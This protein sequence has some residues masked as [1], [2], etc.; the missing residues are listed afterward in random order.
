MYQ[1][2]TSKLVLATA[3][4]LAGCTSY[5]AD[6]LRP[7]VELRTLQARTPERALPPSVQEDLG[8]RYRHEDGLDEAE[9]VIAA[10]NFNPELR[11]KRY[12]MSRL[13]GFDLLGM[14]KFKPELQVNLDRATVGVATD[15][16]TLYTLLIPS[17]RQAWRDD[18]SARREQS[19]AE[20]LAAEV[21]VVV[22]VRRAH[23]GVLAGAERLAW[24]QRRVV[25][26]RK[27]LDQVES[28][29][30][31]TPL[32]R[33]MASLAWERA[34]GDVRHES[35]GLDGARR[36]LNQTIGFDPRQELRLTAI[37]Q[38]LA[39]Q[40]SG[41]VS[42]DE[43]DQH[44]IAGRWELRAL[45][46]SYRRAEYTYSQ[47]VVGQYPKLRLAPAVSYDREEG[48]SFKLGASVKVPWPE[49]AERK[50]EDAHQERERARA[51]Y[52]ARLHQ[53]RAEAHAANARLAAAIADLTALERSRSVADAAL[54]AGT[55]RHEQGEL[56]L[57]DYLPLVERCEDI[58][59][60]WIEAA[61]DY[62]LSRI[63]VD[64]ATGRINQA[65]PEKSSP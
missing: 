38:P 34:L 2:M 64:H 50:M 51:V 19:R 5:R 37:G 41:V 63:D 16:D 44:L 6:P 36:I 60:A 12:G 59:R 58:A 29:P 53:L 55:S 62:R 18:E 14:V 24:A 33:A 13:G 56:S 43:L 9:L 26:R 30:R 15:S 25:H 45:E 61:R 27:M 1:G 35:S 65:R 11:D 47:A 10:L 42:D 7:S 39:S 49:D 8:N 48:T 17:L 31:A 52:L 4:L 20:M 28:D 54:A 21:Q 3:V 57:S 40:P 22:D 46:A 23:I 32:D